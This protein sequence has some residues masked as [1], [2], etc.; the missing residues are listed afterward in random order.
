M[1]VVTLQSLSAKTLKKVVHCMVVEEIL[2]LCVQ[3]S[4]LSQPPWKKDTCAVAECAQKPLATCRAQD[5]KQ[6]LQR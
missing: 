2:V 1:E 6:L 5:E 4:E 3:G